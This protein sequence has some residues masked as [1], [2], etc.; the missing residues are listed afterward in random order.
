[1]AASPLLQGETGDWEVVLGLDAV[2]DEEVSE[3]VSAAR[4]AVDA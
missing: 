3:E 1:M 2:G 4:R